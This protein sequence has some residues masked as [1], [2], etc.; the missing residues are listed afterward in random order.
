MIRDWQTRCKGKYARKPRFFRVFPH[1]DSPRPTPA[2]VCYTVKKR[3][4][5]DLRQIIENI[6][7]KY[8]ARPF[9]PPR[10]M[11]VEEFL[12]GDIIETE[13]G[14]HFETEKLWEH[15]RHHGSADIGA[16]ASLP[17]DLLQTI[18]EM[19]SAIP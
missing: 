10:R 19:P 11:P 6:N 13:F 18:G 4:M 2:R 1:A 5:N 7:R 12:P 14:R 17:H 15:H 3:R 16:L 9:P 8:D